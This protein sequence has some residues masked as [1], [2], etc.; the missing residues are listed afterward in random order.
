MYNSVYYFTRICTIIIQFEYVYNY[1]IF[2]Y[3][4]YEFTLYYNIVL[5]IN[6]QGIIH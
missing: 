3:G 2:K 1:C 6:Y 4:Y 5:R